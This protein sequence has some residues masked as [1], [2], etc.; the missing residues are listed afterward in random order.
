MK[1]AL[2]IAEKGSLRRNLESVYKKY[3]DEI[4]YDITFTEQ[5]GHL[6]T[7]KNPT[8]LDEDMK[9]WSFDTLPFHPEEHGGWKYK[10]IER[11]K[12]G[13]FQTP[14]EKYEYIK[15][16]LKSGKYD[17]VINA[18][19]PDQEGELLIR[20]VLKELECDIPILRYWSNDQ[21]EQ[22]VLEAFKN[23]KDD[24]HDE[25]LINLL[26]AAYGRQHSDYRFG[27]NIS[28]AATLKMN[29]R[30]ACGRVKTPILGIVCKR[31]KEIENFIPKTVYG[32]KVNYE[33]G[34]LGNLYD[35]SF[36][37][38]EEEDKKKKDDEQSG[39]V[40]F[41]TK[42]EAENLISSL[43]YRAEVVRFESRKSKTSAPKLFKLATAQIAAGKMGYT[44]ADTLSII[45]G[46]YEKG[47][48][49]YPRTDCEYISSGENLRAMLESA[50]CVEEL[51]PFIL[52]ID[53]SA[54]YD[55]KSTPKWVNDKALKEAGHSA[56]VPT[57][58]KPDFDSLSNDEQKIYTL[59][60]KQFVAIFLPPLI[61]NKK[62]LITNIDDNYFKSTG[63]TLID[64]GYTKIFG[65]KFTDNEIGEFGEGDI[66][67]VSDFEMSEKTSTCPKRFTEADLISVC[68]APHK[69][70]DDQKLKELGKK[71]KI[72]TP[73]T[74]ASI[75][76][77]LIDKDKYLQRKQEKKTTYIVP[78]DAGM[79]IYENLK[80]FQI[81]KVDMSGEWEELLEDVRMGRRTLSE[82]EEKM[83]HDVT[84]MVKE[85]QNSQMT[86][87]MKSKN[88]I[89][90]C[91]KCGGDLLEGQKSYY[92]AGYKEGC[93]I[94][95][96]NKI[97]DSKIKP[98]EFVSLISG[99]TIKKKIKKGDKNWEQELIYDFDEHKIQ[100]VKK[101][102][103]SAPAEESDYLCPNC[104]ERLFEDEKK[105]RCSCGFTFWKITGK[106]QLSD[107]EIASFFR[108]GET[109][110]VE[111]LEGKS[112]KKFKANIVLSDD[113]KGTK[114]KFD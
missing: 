62:I 96:F 110:I 114:Y 22:K 4:P 91:P 82:L 47:Y 34:F 101:E 87:V 66:I 60:A 78:S 32:V 5:S 28:R 69:W 89:G 52:D 29:S 57:T 77:E 106:K 100:F 102:Y 98:D 24:E 36:D 71:L 81:C 51:K 41:E 50:S 92:C 97:C 68:E 25:M 107:D 112:G 31:E 7:L 75:I 45:Q 9:E 38:N 2:L 43:S 93:N 80:D 26:N 67:V 113:K 95:A 61:Q 11:K 84:Q 1:K 20:I 33:D 12:E 42:E 90:T 35:S 6:M 13:N 85:L 55:V 10:V 16:E 46:L 94:G 18:G 39:L 108:T 64:E 48:I 105:Y 44:P 21:T 103:T 83:K 73:A 63:K 54:I 76:K 59:I 74:R 99:K 19:D 8:E 70:L 79:T 109:G 14:K 111:G 23:L 40:W 65:T 86:V 56:L 30:V 53:D 3:K 49:S 15:Q 104:D 27:M 37:N 88:V 17:C 58:K 72:G